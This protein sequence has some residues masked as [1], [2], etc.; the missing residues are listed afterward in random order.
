MSGRC[1]SSRFSHV[2]LADADMVDV[3]HD[4]QLR[5]ADFA[6]NVGGLADRGIEIARLVA[7]VDRFEQQRQVRR[8]LRRE[9][10]VFDE[11]LLRGAPC[12][13]ARRRRP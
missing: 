2:A 13:R 10:E 6:D 3:E 12:A 7:L 8:G 9:G 5:R 1:R 11:D 4:L